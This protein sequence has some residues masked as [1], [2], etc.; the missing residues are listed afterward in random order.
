MESNPV[1]SFIGLS[2]IQNYTQGL[3]AKCRI[4]DKVDYLL[5]TTRIFSENDT[6]TGTFY[7]ERFVFHTR[8][9]RPYV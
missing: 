3:Y 2:K 6:C 8:L 7:T 4:K 9:E 1:P 5:S